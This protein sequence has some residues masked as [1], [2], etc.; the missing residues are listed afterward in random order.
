MPDKEYK[1][2]LSEDGADKVAKSFGGVD[3][4]VEGVGKAAEDAADPLDQLLG[5][6][7][8][9][10]EAASEGDA[11]AL[12]EAVVVIR[13]AVE[14]L[15]NVDSVAPEAVAELDKMADSFEEVANEAREAEQALQQMTRAESEAADEAAR[16]NRPLTKQEMN[17]EAVTRAFKK[18]TKALGPTASSLQKVAGRADEVASVMGQMPGPVGGAAQAIQGVLSVAKGHPIL[19]AA[20]LALTAVA[21]GAKK[22][23]DH[24][25]RVK[26]VAKV[27]LPELAKS[28]K[29]AAIEANRLEQ[30]QRR[31]AEAIRNSNA[32]VSSYVASLRQAAS[33][34][35]SLTDAELGGELALIDLAELE[36]NLTE[37]E[38][39]RARFDARRAAAEEKRAMEREQLEKEVEITRREEKEATEDWRETFPAA[40]AASMEFDLIDSANP[41]E[42]PELH[43]LD[44]AVDEASDAYLKE[45]S[46]RNPDPEKT[47]EAKKAAEEARQAL[48]D[49]YDEIHKAALEAREEAFEATREAERRIAEKRG[50]KQEAEGALKEFDGPSQKAFDAQQGTES[51]RLEIEEKRHEK[52]AEAERQKAE[53]QAAEQRIEE[54]ETQGEEA[55]QEV[56]ALAERA[57]E[58][59]ANVESGGGAR[60]QGDREALTAIR[61]ALDALADGVDSGETEALSAAIESAANQTQSAFDVRDG[62]LRELVGKLE[63]SVERERERDLA[64][65]ELRSIVANLPN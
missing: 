56:G 17:L 61:E 23:Y 47:K 5:R 63:A 48:V 7:N 53:K 60:H 33:A 57:G 16:L 6:L 19:T 50:E 20:A 3:E 29:D 21:I 46:S 58:V 62:V 38:A 8:E 27:G 64:I 4:A 10:A 54:L 2:K 65:E 40:R 44:V 36:G 14:E 13:E 9:I 43:D 22:I 51:T 32:G 11:A 30:S 39:M 59:T 31:A 42:L 55:S 37:A 45:K 25:Q 49:T 18:K 24:Y 12:E 28:T 52:A 1:I 15:E 34:Q 35:A 41:N 26:E